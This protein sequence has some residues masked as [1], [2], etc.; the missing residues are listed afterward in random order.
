MSV[1]QIYV[2]IKCVCIHNN[3]LLRSTNRRHSLPLAC[4]GYLPACKIAVVASIRVTDVRRRHHCRR[5]PLAYVAHRLTLKVRDVVILDNFGSHMRAGARGGSR[6]AAR[7]SLTLS[8]PPTNV[9]CSHWLGFGIP[10]AICFIASRHKNAA[11][12]SQ[13]AP[14]VP[15]SRNMF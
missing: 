3:M 15:P 5:L 9:L 12:T 14:D 8:S 1:R 13:Q 4:A 6:L 2:K 11:T 7:P 10:W